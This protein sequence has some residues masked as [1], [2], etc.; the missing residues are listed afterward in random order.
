MEALTQ[1]SHWHVS[2]PR[3]QVSVNIL[4]HVSIGII[5]VWLHFQFSFLSIVNSH[6]NDFL[7]L[8]LGY[9][10][11]CSVWSNLACRIS[12]KTSEPR[13]LSQVA[14]NGLLGSAQMALNE[15]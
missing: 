3:L 10:L 12:P 8:D 5:M 7:V 11:Y 9:D 13:T 2:S 15:L 4:G 6:T 1:K 14:H